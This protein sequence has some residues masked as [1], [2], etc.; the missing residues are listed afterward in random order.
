MNSSG[1]KKKKCTPRSVALAVLIKVIKQGKSLSSLKEDFQ[2]LDD[3]RDR[4]L[5]TEITNG[6]LRWRWKLDGILSRQLKKSIRNKDV[7]IKVIL[8]I[9]IYEL[10]ELGIPDYATVNEAVVL[11]KST[12]KIWAKSLVNA[13]LRNV[14]RHMDEADALS[15]QDEAELYS[16]P[17]WLISI[18]KQDWPG[19]WRHILEANNQRPPIWLRVNQLQSS[20]SDYQKKLKSQSI[21]FSVHPD[22]DE[23]IKIESKINVRELPGFEAGA[24]SVQDAGA[25]Y[26]AHLLD[27][28]KGERVL[29]L[30]AAPGG[31]TCHIL[32]TYPEL[33]QLVAVDNV[34]KRMLRVAENLTRLKLDAT[35]ISG[36]ATDVK[37]W[38]DGELFDCILVDA[39]CSAAGVIRRHPDIKSL[40]RE[41]DLPALVE[42]Q[43]DILTQAWPMLAPG[44]RMLYITC[45]VLKQENE[46]QIKRFMSSHDDAIEGTL[47]LDVGVE[48]ETGRQMMPGEMDMDGFYYAY[49]HK[50]A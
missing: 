40:R 11:V 46:Y 6:V 3:N 39:P 44:G 37:T 1:A 32:E 22:I 17:P 29:D 35:L 12:K 8:W 23:A 38:W 28:K 43:Q 31:K 14:I 47:E 20:G 15:G 5:A 42:I 4:S 21:E 50:Q 26:A 24:V 10:T 36:D 19:H 9:A 25:Q 49:L 13:V 45:S 41:D 2:V 30:C 27:V 18:L 7:D 33:K 16:H 34:E 48:C